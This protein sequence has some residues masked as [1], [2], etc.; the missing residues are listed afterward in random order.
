MIPGLREGNETDFGLA[1]TET[2]RRCD[3]DKQTQMA[4]RADCDASDGDGRVQLE[5]FAE[6]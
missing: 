1:C 3:S 5:G 6:M 4:E 2:E